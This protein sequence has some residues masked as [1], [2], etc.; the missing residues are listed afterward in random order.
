M[1][2]VQLLQ[3]HA[4]PMLAQSGEGSRDHD[5]GIAPR[6]L[7]DRAAEHALGLGPGW[8]E[9]PAA[10]QFGQHGVHLELSERPAETAANAAP[11]RNPRVGPGRV[12]QKPLWL[13]ALRV[14]IYIRPA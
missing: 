3:G 2:F 11:E 5:L 8:R 9:L 12:V 13:E 14:G 7:G 10:D 4:A 1:G 6:R